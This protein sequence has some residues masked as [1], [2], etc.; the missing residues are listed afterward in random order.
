MSKFEKLI[1]DLL[2]L[3][4]DMR[5]DEIQKILEYYGFVMKQPRSGSSH[6]VFRHNN[7]KRICIPKANPVNKC[8]VKDVK[9]LLVEMINDDTK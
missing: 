1:E 3:S 5:F 9:N 7:G 2:S 4:R 8:Y 6:Y